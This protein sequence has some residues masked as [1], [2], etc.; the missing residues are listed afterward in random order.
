MPTILGI[1][2]G[3]TNSVVAV[4]DGSGPRVL[5]NEEGQRVTPSVVSWLDDG[6]ILVGASARRQRITRPETT[7][8]SAKRLIGRRFG[9]PHLE[10]DAGGHTLTESPDG[11]AAFRILDLQVTPQEVAAHILAKLR[12]AAEQVLGE[13][14]TDAVITVPAYFDDAQRQATRQAGALAGLQVKRILNEPTAAALAA[15]LDTSTEQ[16][17]AVFDFGGGTFDVS[18]LDIAEDMVE[19]LS[20][21]GDTRLGGD[22]IDAALV[23]WLCNEFE[24]QHHKPLQRDRQ[25][26]QRL[27]DAAERAKI[28]LSSDSQTEIHLPFLHQQDG[29]PLHLT[30]TL[31]RAQLEQIAGPFVARTIT[32]CERALEDAGLQPS[33]IRNVILVG[34]STR[35]PLVRERVEALFGVRPSTHVNPDEIVALGAAVQGAVL[36]GA[37][38]D[39]LLL[40]VTPLSLGV[41]TRGGLFTRLIDRNTTIPTRARKTFGTAA[42]SQHTVEIHVLQGEREFAAENRSLGRFELCDIPRR[43]RGQAR[44]DV[45]F[46]IDANG[47]VSV[48]ARETTTDRSARIR[49]RGASELP[50]DEVERIVSSAERQRRSDLAARERIES[51]QTVRAYLERLRHPEVDQLPIPPDDRERLAEIVAA[52]EQYLEGDGNPQPVINLLHEGG[53]IVEDARIAAGAK[54]H[55]AQQTTPSPSEADPNPRSPT[56]E[57]VASSESGKNPAPGE[58]GGHHADEPAADT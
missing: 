31:H 54:R 50:R 36:A 7:V 56:P 49:I 3:T 55:A 42:D 13:E 5:L 15:G 14:I 34:G 30:T 29:L 20:T 2:L 52:A 24:R 11:S 58:S 57:H 18:L 32:C 33:D 38:V 53:G 48:S 21:A 6:R 9:D 28:S 10:E 40:D 44:I 37:D 12:H 19:V 45:S 35:I 22:D 51:H 41:E 1:D 43:P 25:V 27:R 16:R 23:E 26:D 17:V 8:A 47:I 46:D 39:M 4:H